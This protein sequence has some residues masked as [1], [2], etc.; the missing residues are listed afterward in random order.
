VY[1]T[2]HWPA[3]VNAPLLN[4]VVFVIFVLRKFSVSSVALC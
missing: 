1:I 3:E 4:F 2:P